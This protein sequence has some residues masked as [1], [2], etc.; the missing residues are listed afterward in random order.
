MRTPSITKEVMFFQ[1]KSPDKNPGN[2]I[3]SRINQ[4][5]TALFGYST[6][7]NK[8][9]SEYLTRI[10]TLLDDVQMIGAMTNRKTFEDF[11]N[12]LEEGSISE[13]LQGRLS[14]AVIDG[15]LARASNIKNIQN[16]LI[17]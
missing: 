1:D 13:G 4:S 7:Y 15:S 16:Y 3:V 8:Q 17:Y 5:A 2:Y 6:V 9:A 10:T 11:T 14:G 12:F